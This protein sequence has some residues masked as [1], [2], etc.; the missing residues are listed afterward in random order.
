M[1]DNA[2]K[3]NDDKNKVYIGKLETTST[4]FIRR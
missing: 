2:R 3:N 1:P 4:L